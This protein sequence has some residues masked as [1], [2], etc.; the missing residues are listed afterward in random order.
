MLKRR[1]FK[2]FFT[3]LMI[4]FI[5]LLGGFG[6]R[7][8]TLIPE[9]VATIGDSKDEDL[10]INEIYLK[11]QLRM[12]QYSIQKQHILNTDKVDE[13]FWNTSEDGETKQKKLND[14]L[15]DSIK[16]QLVA[17]DYAKENNII[18]DVDD[19]K[20]V[21]Q[22]KSQHSSKEEINFIT[23]G[24]TLDEH[25]FNKIFTN[26]ILSEKAISIGANKETLS[27]D[28]SLEKTKVSLV[29]EIIIS[30][31]EVSDTDKKEN[32]DAKKK[33]AEKIQEEAVNGGSL[34]DLAAKYKFG[35]KNSVKLSQYNIDEKDVNKTSIEVA[36][37]LKKDEISSVVPLYNSKKS[38]DDIKAFVIFKCIN[39]NIEEETNKNLVEETNIKKEEKFKKSLIDKVNNTNFKIND[40][41]FQNLK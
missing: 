14:F 1:K 6:Y 32:I 11:Y 26:I 10:K 27:D 25:I 35:Y 9:T 33:I 4:T 5:C 37:K 21:E 31:D 17:L 16:L 24:K 40:K 38:E 12:S 23:D 41:L 30:I 29:E 28:N 36:T 18:L 15:L 19:L 13:N 22:L 34:E 8:L 7:Y 3:I 2:I 39:D 20:K